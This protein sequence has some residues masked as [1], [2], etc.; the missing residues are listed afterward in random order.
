MQHPL[1][2]ARPSSQGCRRYSRYG[3]RSVGRRGRVARTYSRVRAALGDALAV[4]QRAIPGKPTRHQGASA[5]RRPAARHRVPPRARS[6]TGPRHPPA[7]CHRRPHTAR[8]R[9]HPG[10]GDRDLG[11]PASASSGTARWSA[12]GAVQ[13]L[14]EPGAAAASEQHPGYL[15]QMLQQRAAAPVAP[16]QPLDLLSERPPTAARAVTEQPPNRQPDQ[17]RPPTDSDIGQRTA[18]ATVHPC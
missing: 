4:D 5:A 14:Q 16:S 3:S 7:G 2:C 6:E 10:H 15:H 1:R 12:T 9:P 8:N 17:H 11:E 13:D 18:I